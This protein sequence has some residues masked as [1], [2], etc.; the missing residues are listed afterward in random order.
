MTEYFDLFWALVS[1]PSLTLFWYAAGAFAV[2]L[3]FGWVSDATDGLLAT[4]IAILALIAFVVLGGSLFIHGAIFSFNAVSTFIGPVMLLFGIPLLIILV[5][6]LLLVDCVLFYRETEFWGGVTFLIALLLIGWLAFQSLDYVSATVEAHGGWLTAIVKLAGLWVAA[7][8]VTAFGKWLQ[9]SNRVKRFI[10][11]A[12]ESFKG[13]SAEF[14]LRHVPGLQGFGRVSKGVMRFEAEGDGFTFK[15]NSGKFRDLMLD[16]MTYWPIHL[17]ILL[18]ADLFRVIYDFII[19]AFQGV[20]RR[21]TMVIW[22]S[23]L[24]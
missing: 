8:A 9:L 2:M 6:A 23:V 15:L 3:L 5:V 18:F 13:T 10:K 1:E 11:E 12:R 19:D 16:W 4:G 14:F 7:G 24:K 21:I 22:G 17:T 20:A